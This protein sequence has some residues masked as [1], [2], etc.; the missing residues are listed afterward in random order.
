MVSGWVVGG[1]LR[2]GKMVNGCERKGGVLC[3]G[4]LL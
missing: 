4:L 2:R 1:D 3:V